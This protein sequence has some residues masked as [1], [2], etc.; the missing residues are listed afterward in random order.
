MLGYD[1]LEVVLGIMQI[2]TR[3]QIANLTSNILNPFLVGLIV[4]LLLSFESTSSILDALKWSL[5]LIAVG[6]LPVF[7]VIVYLV[8]TGGLDSIFTNA[9]EERTKL[10]LLT[11]VCVIVSGVILLQ[12]G[13]PLILVA[14]FIAALIL[15]LVF[16]SINLWWKI[17]VHTAFIAALV[18]ILVILYGPIAAVSAVLLPLIAWARI[19]LRHHSLAQVTTG[20]LLA[21]LIVVVVFSFL[22]LV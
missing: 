1:W 13:A 12:F 20:A 19:K 16:I 4:I 8:Q 11:G 14:T 22:G 6:I 18:T 9:R 3:K 21:T 2:E 17:S 10:Y 15:I 5:I 7:L